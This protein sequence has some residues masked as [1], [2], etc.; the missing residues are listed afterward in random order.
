MVVPLVGVQEVRAKGKRV[1]G[2][3]ALVGGASAGPGVTVILRSDVVLR[4]AIEA[5]RSGPEA[6]ASP[7]LRA[8]SLDTLVGEALIEREA[9]RVHLAAPS[10]AAIRAEVLR[11]E[12]S[13][14]GAAALEKVLKSIGADRDEVRAM[15]TRRALVGAFLRANLEGT[16]VV[17]DAQVQSAYRD[18]RHPFGDR[19]EEEARE[20]LRRWLMQQALDVA[21][22]RWIRVLGA[23]TT[24]VRMMEIAGETPAGP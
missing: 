15:A 22:A 13:V 8:A 18:G 12:A 7:E 3:A 5:A 20:P 9:N 24:T 11:F 6:G 21:V 14:G 17:T 16:V 23:R 19:S 2:I 1:E 4:A 10:T